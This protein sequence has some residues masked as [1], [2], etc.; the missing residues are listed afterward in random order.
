MA[1]SRALPA[2]ADKDADHIMLVSWSE[3]LLLHDSIWSTHSNSHP[4]S[5]NTADSKRGHLDPWEALC[6]HLPLYSWLAV[7]Q[8][9]NTEDC[10]HS[11]KPAWCGRSFTGIH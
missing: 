2:T 3:P 1:V 6:Q 4:P 9:P 8:L 7:T 11:H 5:S 10:H